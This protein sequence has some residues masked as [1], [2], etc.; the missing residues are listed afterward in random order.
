MYI[1]REDSFLLQQ[2]LKKYLKKQKDKSIKILDLGTGSGIQAET[3]VKLGFKHVLAA[4]IDEE[5]LENTKKKKINAIKSNLFEK[6]KAKFDLIIFNPPYLQQDKHDRK[7]DTT[8][9]RLGDETIINFLNQ[10]KNHLTKTGAILLLLSSLTPRNKIDELIKENYKE[11]KV[12]E[13]K[14]F[15]EKLEVLL[16]SP[17]P[18]T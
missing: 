10:A 9:G 4:D 16:L 11:K 5:A 7:N 8:G 3:C 15:F 2:V 1:P 13:K 6:V 14:L 18:E 17:L 12:A